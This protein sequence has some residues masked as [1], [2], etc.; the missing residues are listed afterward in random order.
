MEFVLRRRN[1]HELSAVKATEITHKLQYVLSVTF[2]V[3]YFNLSINTI[4]I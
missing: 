1:K 3:L 2:G 4:T